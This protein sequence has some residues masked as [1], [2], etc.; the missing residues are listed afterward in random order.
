[1]ATSLLRILLTIAFP[2]SP[3]LD[4]NRKKKLLIVGQEEECLR[5]LNLLKQT[6]VRHELIGFVK[7]GK[8]SVKGEFIGTLDQLEEIVRVNSAQEII[9]CSRDISSREIIQYMLGLS[10]AR[11][12][13]KIAPQ[14]SISII[15]SNSIDSPGE[16]YVLDFNLIAKPSNKRIKRVFDI[17]AS[18]F[19]LIASPVLLFIVKKPHLLILNLLKVLFGFKSLIGY[20]DSPNLLALNLPPIKKSILNPSSGQRSALS[21][22]Q[23]DKL[24]L[25]YARDYKLRNDLVILLRGIKYLDQI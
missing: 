13:Y 25:L 10:R 2:K 24:N 20:C 7:P 15:G 8:E 1:V 12:D 9:F 3:L 18:F 16:L 19:L 14:E 5:V 22:E 21:V 6:H 17:V 23:I 4:L 11:V